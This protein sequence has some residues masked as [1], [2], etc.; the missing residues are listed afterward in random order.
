MGK[1][2]HYKVDGG[3]LVRERQYCPECGPGTFMA[4]HVDRKSCGRCGH[5]VSATADSSD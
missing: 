1:I 5:T 3:K 2:E 4:H